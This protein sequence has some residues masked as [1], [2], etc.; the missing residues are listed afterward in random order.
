MAASLYQPISSK[1]NMS[2]EM[3]CIYCQTLKDYENHC[4]QN[5]NHFLCEH[6]YPNQNHIRHLGLKGNAYIWFF[7]FCVY[8]KHFFRSVWISESIVYLKMDHRDRGPGQ[9]LFVTAVHGWCAN[10]SGKIP[11]PIH[12]SVSAAQK[13]TCITSLG[14]RTVAMLW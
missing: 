13:I 12:V 2:S 5:T 1:A 3:P 10:L 14:A 7:Y 6:H 8:F 11:L 4:I 9:S